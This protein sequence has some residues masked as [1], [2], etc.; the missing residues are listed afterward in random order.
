[1]IINNPQDLTPLLNAMRESLKADVNAVGAK[2]ESGTNVLSQKITNGNSEII[3]DIGAL[4]TVNGEISTE[5]AAINAHTSSVINTAKAGINQ[6]VTSKNLDVKN[7]QFSGYFKTLLIQS[8]SNN[9]SGSEDSTFELVNITGAGLINN[10]TSYAQ[11][12]KLV[13]LWLDGHYIEASWGD[14]SRDNGI[15]GQLSFKES[16]RIVCVR[17]STAGA[18]TS[19]LI[20]LGE[21][22]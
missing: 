4:T 6:H 18:G 9:V 20:S 7:S 3:Q 2:V 12:V 19:A 5:V 11:R 10:V 22:S 16:L 17:G 1:M 15:I 14:L 13:K 8:F 21:W